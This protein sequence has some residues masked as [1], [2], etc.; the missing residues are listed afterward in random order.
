LHAGLRAAFDAVATL[1][2]TPGFAHCVDV[3][4]GF[5]DEL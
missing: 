2:Y 4:G 5:L 3:V 1:D